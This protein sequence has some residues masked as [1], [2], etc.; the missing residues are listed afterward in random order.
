MLTK[1]SQ[2]TF[3]KP[4]TPRAAR[5]TG[6]IVLLSKVSKGAQIGAHHRGGKRNGKRGTPKRIVHRTE[7]VRK[8]SD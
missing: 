5:K 2:L 1:A 3:P 7:F 4:T 6:R 8:I